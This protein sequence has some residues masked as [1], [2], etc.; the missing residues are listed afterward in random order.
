MK[1]NKTYEYLERISNL[2]RV[3]SRQEGGEHGLQPVQLDVLHYLSIC[4][5]YSDTPMGVTEYLGLTKGTVSQTIKVLENKGYVKKIM[6]RDDK[7][8][9]HLNLTADGDRLVKK[10]IPSHLFT[11]AYKELSD[12]DKNALEEALQK[13]LTSMIMINMTRPFGVCHTCRYHQTP[14]QGEYFCGLVEKPIGESEIDMI[15]REH[16]QA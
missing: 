7:R 12:K 6:D 9:M 4:N 10:S 11:A 3:G 8:V 2:L 1:N 16:E 5:S 14:A 13:M 15:C